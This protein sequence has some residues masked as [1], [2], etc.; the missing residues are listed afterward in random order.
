MKKLLIISGMLLISLIGTGCA[1]RDTKEV[2]EKGTLD[3]GA[4]S[5]TL[6][7]NSDN[8]IIGRIEDSKYK[9]P[10]RITIEPFGDFDFSPQSVK[11]VR[12]DIFREGFFSV[13]DVLVH[14][15]EKGEIDLVY[16]FD[17]EMNT[18]VIDSINGETN[19]W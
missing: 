11:T 19:Y 2:K 18:H 6:S 17:R 4:L 14:L 12:G 16:H 5:K 7:Q 15:H 1:A 9:N 10:G 8:R 3:K 13:F